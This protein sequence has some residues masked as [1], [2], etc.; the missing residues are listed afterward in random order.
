MQSEST[1]L[2]DAVDMYGIDAYVHTVN[3]NAPIY[4]L[5]DTAVNG[6]SCKPVTRP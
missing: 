2:N 6:G 1:A 4:I 5:A 3:Y